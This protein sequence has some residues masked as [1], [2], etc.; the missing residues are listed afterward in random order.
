MVS[1]REGI[2]NPSLEDVLAA[3]LKA[4]LK[5]EVVHEKK[6]PQ[7][8]HEC[9][10]HILVAKSGPKTAIVKRIAGALKGRH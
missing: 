5:P 8:W 3:A 9:S 1:L 6:H 4:G 2:S 7:K 10:G